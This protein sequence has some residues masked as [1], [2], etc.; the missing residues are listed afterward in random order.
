MSHE[1]FAAFISP[2]NEAGK[3]LQSHF[4]ALQLVMTPFTTRE[5]TG[6]QNSATLAQKPG[7]T[8]GWLV[9]I[10]RDIKPEMMM[11]YEWP[12]WVHREVEAGRLW[13][14]DTNVE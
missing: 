1:E 6:R 9:A 3:L 13:N 11:Y 7:S 12:R 8:G 10:H 4:V 5:S 14:D 2:L